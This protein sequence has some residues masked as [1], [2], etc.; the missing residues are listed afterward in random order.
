MFLKKNHCAN[1][2]QTKSW[3]LFDT[4]LPNHSVMCYSM[5]QLMTVASCCAEKSIHLWDL[6][7]SW[8]RVW[9]WRAFWHLAP[10]S[11]KVDQCFRG[12][13]CFHHQ[14]D[15]YIMNEWWMVMNIYH[16]DDRGNT[17][18]WN[19]CLLQ[20]DYTVLYPRRLSS[21]S[22]SLFVRLLNVVNVQW[23]IATI[24][25]IFSYMWKLNAALMCL[26]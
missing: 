10:C 4:K 16:P 8:Q 12:A 23:G 5:H 19:V 9:I 2:I 14:G 26:N 7:F 11:L 15:E 17:H 18:L 1:K 20:R 25:Y 6:R 21:W 13:Y 3:Q 22:V 24:K